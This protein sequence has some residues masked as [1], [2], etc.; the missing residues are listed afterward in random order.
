MSAAEALA[1]LKAEISALIDERNRLRSALHHSDAWVSQY[2]TMPGHDAAARFM[3]SVIRAALKES[4][5]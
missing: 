5:K 2:E 3:L 1:S 4:G